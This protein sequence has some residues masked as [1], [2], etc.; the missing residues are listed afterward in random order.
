MFISFRSRKLPNPNRWK[1]KFGL[2][3]I[4]LN[5][6]HQKTNR[7][8]WHQKKRVYNYTKERWCSERLLTAAM[9]RFLFST[10]FSDNKS[11][12]AFD[13]KLIVTSHNKPLDVTRCKWRAREAWARAGELERG[14]LALLIQGKKKTWTRNTTW[15]NKHR[16]H[17]SNEVYLATNSSFE[18]ITSS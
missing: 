10:W 15:A 11:I 9:C 16:S 17:R 1:T 2:F 6:I 5:K 14:K 7:W 12:L 3:C 8:S 4:I 13:T 18:N